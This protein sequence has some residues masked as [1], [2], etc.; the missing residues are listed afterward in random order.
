MRG[1]PR[2]G[3]AALGHQVRA[4]GHHRSSSRT[5][6]TSISPASSSSSGWPKPRNRSRRAW[7]SPWGR[8][9]RPWARSTNTRSRA[10]PP[11]GS[12]TTSRDLTE[13]RTL[14]DWPISPAA[15]DHPRRQRGQLLRR[16]YQA[17][18]RHRRPDKLR[19]YGLPLSEVGRGLKRNNQNVGGNIIQKASQQYLVRG[20][21]LLR[22]RG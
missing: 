4:L 7:R 1:L 22:S 21:G 5:G 10:G 18:S 19:K 8:W 9:P 15:Q 3:P 11:P 13:L 14:Q 16:L 2:P 20:I 6:S 12:E 17:I